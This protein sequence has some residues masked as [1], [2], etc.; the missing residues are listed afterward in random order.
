MNSKKSNKGLRINSNIKS[1]NIRVIDKEGNDIGIFRLEE[2][3]K[4]AK[5]NSLDLVEVSSNSSPPVCKIM[6]YGRF[7]Y[8]NQK[9]ISK[10]KK[11]Q[12]VVLIKEIKIRTNIGESDYMIKLKKTRELL[13]EGN[14]VKVTLRFRGREIVHKDIGVN[15]LNKI[16][17]DTSD[18]S[19][20]DKQ[21]SG[22]GHQIFIL[23]S[24]N[25]K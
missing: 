23:L 24:P 25:K 12:K 7:K 5:E 14:K 13:E 8:E 10:N 6:D 1:Q 17:S 16:H 2:G 15:L 20:L 11:K 21:P 18:I 3:I 22:E 19:V 9:K 4:K